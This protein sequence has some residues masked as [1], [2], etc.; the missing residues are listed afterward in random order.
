MD[1]EPAVV[2]ERGLLAVSDEVWSRAVRHAQVIGRLARADVV[3]LEAADGGA[4]ELGV[5]RRQVYLLLRRWREGEGVVSDLIPRRSS[6]GRGH[7]QL[8]DEIEALIR[9]LL[10]TR[11]LTRQKRSAAAVHR[12]LAR[13]CRS[14]GWRVPS[15]GTLARRIAKL[16]PVKKVSAREG[17]DAA[18]ALESAGGTAPAVA[19]VLEQVQIDHTVI[20]L[21][22]VDE[23][24]RLPIGRPYITVAIDVFCRCIVGLVVTLE[25][26]SALSVGLCLA[27]MVTDKRAWLERLG[28]QAGWP[29][30]GKPAEL[31]LDNAAEFKGEALRRGCEQHG[32]RLRYRPPG[33][34]HY[35]GIIERVIG[36]MMEAVHELP[37]T[38]FSSPRQR[39]GYDSDATAVLTV[40][41]LE[42]WLTLAAAPI[43]RCRTGRCR[44]RRSA[45]G[46]S[47]PQWRG[48][49][50]PAAPRSTRTPCS[51]WP[52]RCARSPRPPRRPPARPGAIRNAAPPCPHRVACRRQ[53]PHRIALPPPQPRRRRS[54]WLRSGDDGR[55]PA[56]LSH[57][58]QAAQVVAL[59][60]A[61][62]R[63]RHVRADRWI[64]YSRATEAL[65]R[66]ESLFAWPARQRM[67]NLLL[68]GRRCR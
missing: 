13:V 12:E 27:H 44:I 19:A 26:P 18:R 55:E 25:A 59:L 21:I 3:G 62:E 67:P 14:R 38:T 46:S 52:S 66:L 41:E 58:H 34:P 60:P 57:L 16:D 51:G 47:A 32:V 24:H 49:G 40:R 1:D 20:D 48:C 8:P 63:L 7:E 10:P 65:A 22:V 11:Y 28:V 29:M 4:A 43:C 39:G 68:I 6:G 23:R 53:C 37:G 17:P 50:S 45:S 35:G 33:Q 56:D 9:D 64:G 31:F 5:S 36:T 54:R 42:R 2:A 30:S 61:A 15:R